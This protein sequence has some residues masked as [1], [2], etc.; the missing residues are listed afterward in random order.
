VGSVKPAEG[1]AIGRHPCVVRRLLKP[2]SQRLL[3][4]TAAEIEL[5][6]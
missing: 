6:S 1:N 3:P 2:S 4:G 5:V